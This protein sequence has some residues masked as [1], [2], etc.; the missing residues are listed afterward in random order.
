LIP[1]DNLGT[2]NPDQRP[3]RS[4]SKDVIFIKKYFDGEGIVNQR[5]TI[6]VIFYKEL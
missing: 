2:V 1:P 4:T 3:N 6:T 5:I